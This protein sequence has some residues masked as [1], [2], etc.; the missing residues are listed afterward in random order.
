M[1]T[2][3]GHIR[4]LQIVLLH[5]KYCK[6]GDHAHLCAVMSCHCET[7]TVNS[8]EGKKMDKDICIYIVVRAV[9]SLQLFT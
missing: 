6:D 2:D 9:P 5:V 1:I 3:R 4:A 8:Y 7:W